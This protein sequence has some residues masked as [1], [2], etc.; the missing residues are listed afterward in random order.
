MANPIYK[1]PLAQSEAISK[2]PPYNKA[3]LVSYLDNF[4]DFVTDEGYE[5]W[6]KQKGKTLGPKTPTKGYNPN[7]AYWTQHHEPT[8]YK[9]QYLA[10][11]EYL[12]EAWQELGND[13]TE[14]YSES[15]PH[16]KVDKDEDY[17]RS[18]G[19]KKEDK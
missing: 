12:Q 10:D 7:S 8:T 4:G 5:A 1:N 18:W 16:H 19:P 2:V 14:W 3:A 11:D 17:E 6:A 13:A 15:T 9:D